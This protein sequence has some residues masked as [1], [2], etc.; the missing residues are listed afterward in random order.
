MTNKQKTYLMAIDAILGEA[1][2]QL[3]AHEY[4]QLCEEVEEH[5]SAN[6]EARKTDE[7][8]NEC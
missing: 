8:Y 3:S 4:I 6:A 7:D 1:S 5:A 2:Y